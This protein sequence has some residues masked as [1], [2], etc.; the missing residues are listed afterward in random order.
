MMTSRRIASALLLLCASLQ[1]PYAPADGPGGYGA[2]YKE[3]EAEYQR[4]ALDA[5]GTGYALI[6]SANRLDQD[7]A[8]ATDERT[9]RVAT[10]QANQKYEDALRAFNEAARLEPGMY[11]AHTYIGYAN[12]K[13]GRYDP[14]LS[15]YT[16][17]LRL[18]PDY[19]PAIEYQGEAYLGLNRFEQARFNYLRLYALDSAQAQKLLDAMEAWS[20]DR[21]QRN[22]GISKDAIN[23]ATEWI[24]AQRRERKRVGANTDG[25]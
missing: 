7:A 22:D 19:M 24:E 6:E 11:E 10:A 21:T 2:R 18:K 17:A 23:A 13:L 25:W 3:M 15:A 20:T 16:A 4:S 14:S 8:A 5:Y 9:R 1:A 12:R